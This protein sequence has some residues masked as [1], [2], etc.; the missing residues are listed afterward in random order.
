MSVVRLALSLIALMVLLGSPSADAASVAIVRPANA[1]PLMVETLGRLRGELASVG[2][3]IEMVDEAAGDGVRDFHAS[4]SWIEQL[5]ARR[6]LD[7]VLAFQGD[8]APDSVE[9][10]V[11]DKVNKKS[12]V[13]SISLVETVERVP[14]TL[15]IRA[16]ELLRS[17][18]LEINLAAHEKRKEA[19]GAP[20]PLVGQI[21][22]K[23]PLASRPERFG[24]ELGGHAVM[25]LEG[26]G[27]AV[28]PMVRFDWA[29]QPSLVAQTTLAGL[30]TH[31]TVSNQE[32]SA[33]IA[34]AYGLLG[35]CYGIGT[36]ERLRPFL[37]VSVGVLH[38]SVDGRT[39]SSANQEQQADKWSVLLDGG[40][41]ARL[42]LRDRLFLSLDLH[43]Q[44]AQPNLSIRLVD[45]V[46]AK[47]GGPNLLAS[48]AVG[49]WL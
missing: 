25:S 49:A 5:A 38:T 48:V 33:E 40:L 19:S 9:V 46:V 23:E 43:A 34:Q 28:L 44:L 16:I 31:P 14:T 3:V 41:G 26:V 45:E 4:R 42:R 2:F 35:V 22:D 29:L 24:V 10:W 6:G 12:V 7:A 13:R 1:S 15:S 8:A 11:V 18:F 39:E 20:P 21:L 30:G 27:P 17:S 37:A 36:T 47:S 32:G